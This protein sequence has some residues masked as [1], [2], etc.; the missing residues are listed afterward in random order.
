L[1]VIRFRFRDTGLLGWKGGVILQ[2]EAKGDYMGVGP[3]IQ[4]LAR[5]E[6]PVVYEWDK[7]ARTEIYVTRTHRITQQPVPALPA[8]TALV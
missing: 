3:A 7:S 8:Q 4:T 6:R 2:K 5:V 1:V